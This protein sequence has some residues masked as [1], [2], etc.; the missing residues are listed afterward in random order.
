MSW[1]DSG[2]RAVRAKCTDLTLTTPPGD[3]CLSGTPWGK[4]SGCLL[5][6]FVQP[7]PSKENIPLNSF[8]FPTQRR[9]EPVIAK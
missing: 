4:G 7:Q 6:E 3:L 9:P 5:L 1:A 8:L 2:G